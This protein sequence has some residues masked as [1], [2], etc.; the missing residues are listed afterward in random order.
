MN[1]PYVG[2]FFGF[3]VIV[4]AYVDRTQ[5]LTDNSLSGPLALFNSKKLKFML[6]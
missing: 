1:C 2:Y 6:S 5:Q 3:D 4:F